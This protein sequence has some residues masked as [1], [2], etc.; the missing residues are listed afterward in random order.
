M[1]I[2]DPKKRAEYDRQRYLRRRESNLLV[3]QQYRD[4]H[5]G[6]IREYFREYR[7]NHKD[8]VAE[9]N[10]LYRETHREELREKQKRYEQ[11]TKEERRTKRR[12]RWLS[13][14]EYRL[15]VAMRNRLNRAI[16]RGARSGSAVRDLGCSIAEL[17]AYLE[18]KFQPGMTWE[19]WSPT[20]WHIDHVRPLASFDLTDRAQFLQACHYT[21]LQPLWAAENLK[22]GATGPSRTAS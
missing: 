17:R 11:L 4:A 18:S 1:P 14:P 8:L 15:S 6:E 20:G 9:R 21:N 13:D 19:N 22:K 7:R 12:A 16:R 2:K 5:R 3:A 10:S